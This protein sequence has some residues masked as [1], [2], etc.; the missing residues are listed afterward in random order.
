MRIKRNTLTLFMLLTLFVSACAKQLSHPA[1][2]RHAASVLLNEF[3]TVFRADSGLIEGSVGD[4]QLNAQE[5][6]YLRMPF[7]HLFRGLDA[8]KSD[9]RTRL[10]A[11][12]DIVLVGAKDFQPP[13]WSRPGTGLGMVHARTCHIMVFE[14]H[15][16][17]DLRGYFPDA[18]IDKV[19]EQ[20]IWRW[21]SPPVEGHPERYVYHIV[22]LETKYLVV[23]NE[24]SDLK[25]VANSLQSRANETATSTDLE[26][27]GLMSRTYWGHRRY[28]HGA[29]V[30]S[31]RA[32]AQDLVTPTA[33]TLTLFV[34]V[35]RKS[36]V[37]GLSASDASAAEKLNAELRSQAGLGP[38]VLTIGKNWEAPFVFDG[39]DVSLERMFIVMGL[40][41][42]GVYL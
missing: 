1:G 12:S 27:S 10:I 14:S 37:L 17:P 5:A 20:P 34:D 4:Q 19:S 36:G 40:F 41:G 29:N 3:E 2:E 11:P 6:A 42:F 7:V 30:T 22:Q 32:S 9:G 38:L 24:L 33:E 15:V 28:R 35:D 26:S 23:C 13:V 25:R 39:S 16:A 18:A 8:W 21:T 31:A